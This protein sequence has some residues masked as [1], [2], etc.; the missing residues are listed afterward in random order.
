VCERIE[1]DAERRLGN[2]RAVDQGHSEMDQS[3]ARRTKRKEA[4]DR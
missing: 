3:V 2:A 4:L 1:A